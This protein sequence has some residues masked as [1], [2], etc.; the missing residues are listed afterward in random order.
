MFWDLD[1]DP[2]VRKRNPDV[3]GVVPDIDRGTAFF[4]IFV[5]CACQ[6]IAKAVA[7]ALLAVTNSAWLLGYIA[8]DHGLHLC[9]RVARRDLVFFVPM[10]T[11]ASYIT[12]PLLRVVVK[13]IN[14]FTGTPL[15]RLPLVLGGSYWMFR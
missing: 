5:M 4:V 13:A 9:Y 8:A 15:L 2:G 11:V 1:T 3:A 10:P 14:D 12:A 7:T 6:I